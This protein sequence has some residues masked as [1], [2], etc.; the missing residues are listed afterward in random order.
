M[1]LKNEV[2]KKIGKNLIT[3]DQVV[4]SKNIN[5]ELGSLIF[6]LILL[7]QRIKLMILILKWNLI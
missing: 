2:V 5:I 6:D 7:N 4:R 3:S 1:R